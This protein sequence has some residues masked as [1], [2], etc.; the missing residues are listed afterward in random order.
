M[1]IILD[2]EAGTCSG[3]R[4]VIELAERELETGNTDMFVIGDVIH[5]ER[6]VE[7]L[8][9]AGLKT[10]H[11]DDLGAFKP[12]RMNS[13]TTILIRAHGEPPS[14]TEIL[15]KLNVRALDGTCPVV[16]KSQRLAK[17][18]YNDNYQVAVVGKHGHP[19]MVGIV[20]YTNHNAVIV[21]YDEDVQ[22]LEKNKP[23]LV[24]AQ[25]TI[26][27]LKFREMSEK[28]EDWVGEIVV[29]NTICDSVVKR[30]ERITAFV[31]QVDVILLVGGHKSS[32]TKEL[33]KTCFAINPRTYQIVSPEEINYDW[34][35]DAEVIGITG[36]AS[37]PLWL[38]KE[39]ESTLKSWNR[40]NMSSIDNK[41]PVGNN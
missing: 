34:F 11:I 13:N 37:T 2:P 19:E 24:M 18:Y 22:K 17:Y 27:P 23:T 28:I 39:F 9:K 33:Y 16:H 15:A 4:R 38:L 1:K 25:T 41:L 7:R 20:G 10:I 12:P 26:H 5:N 21:Q 36:S 35:K 32:N 29:K 30:E 14:T 40:K 8:N 31:R 6:E 3:V